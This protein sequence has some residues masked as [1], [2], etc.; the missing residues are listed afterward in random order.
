MQLSAFLQAQELGLQAVIAAGINTKDVS[1]SAREEEGQLQLRIYV[2]EK[3]LPA[4]GA[5]IPS[6]IG[7]LPV[8]VLPYPN[9]WDT[10][11]REW[12][13]DSAYATE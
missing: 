2:Q 4:A 13:R 6:C 10:A 12:S 8:T 9:T 7:E 1:V 11:P 3:A 5:R